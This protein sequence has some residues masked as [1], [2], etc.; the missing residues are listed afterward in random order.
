MSEKTSERGH[1]YLT[2]SGI[3][4]DVAD[5]ADDITYSSE[6]REGTYSRQI[7]SCIVSEYDDLLERRETR[8]DKATSFSSNNNGFS[9]SFLRPDPILPNVMALDF[10][11][12]LDPDLSDEILRAER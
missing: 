2:L 4:C 11:E 10:Q 9:F 7:E 1:H 6:F 12:L 5:D 8:D 3:T